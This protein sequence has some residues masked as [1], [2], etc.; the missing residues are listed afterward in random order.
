MRL[1]VNRR[2]FLRNASLGSAGLLILRNSASARGFRA[3][4]KLNIALVGVGGRGSWFVRTIPTLGENVVAMCDVNTQKAAEA[5]QRFPD[6]K[7]Y[8]DFRKMLNEMDKQIDAVIV[9]TPDHIHAP[10][11]VMAMKMGKHVYC[12]KPLT[13]NVYESRVMRETA[14]KCKVATQNGQPRH[15]Q[16]GL[17][18]VC[19]NHSGGRAW[20]DSRSACLEHRRWTGSPPASDGSCRRDATRKP[21]RV[22]KVF[23]RVMF[24]VSALY[25][26]RAPKKMRFALVPLGPNENSPAF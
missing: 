13:H 20:R 14:A 2:A 8:Q 9:A 16:R 24:V 4:E 21:L 7:K 5:F 6:V 18:S 3:N 11:S 22:E 15:G 19:G 17:P 25:V 10:A 12:E 26:F 23:D 1:P